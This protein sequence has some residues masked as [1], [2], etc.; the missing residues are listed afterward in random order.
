MLSG[1]QTFTRLTQNLTQAG[2]LPLL[3]K[4]DLAEQRQ[5]E[6][7]VLETLFGAADRQIPRKLHTLSLQN[8]SG[9]APGE[10]PPALISSCTLLRTL[11]LS[12]CNLTG[13]LLCCIWSTSVEMYSYQLF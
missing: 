2:V 8:C 6:G 5:L 11:D 3:E 13:E 9:L 1:S 10:I 7:A 12:H 4:I